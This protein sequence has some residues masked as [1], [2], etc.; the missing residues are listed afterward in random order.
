MEQNIYYCFHKKAIRNIRRSLYL[1]IVQLHVM[2]WF[3]IV[4]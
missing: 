3:L 4:Y 1:W 2:C